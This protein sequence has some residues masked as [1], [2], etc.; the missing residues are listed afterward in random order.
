[1]LHLRDEQLRNALDAIELIVDDKQNTVSKEV[2][3]SNVLFQISV[4][5]SSGS[6]M[7]TPTDEQP[8]KALDL[9]SLTFDENSSIVSSEEHFHHHAP[10]PMVSMVSGILICLINLHPM[11]A[12]S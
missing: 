3:F 1:M 6:M 8:R 7:V 5:P 12:L 2:Q 10:S 4:I 9:I 11:N